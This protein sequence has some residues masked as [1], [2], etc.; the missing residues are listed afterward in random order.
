MKIDQAEL[1]ANL[2]VFDVKA[3]SFNSNY[4][5]VVLEREVV[6]IQDVESLDVCATLC[7]T[8]SKFLTKINGFELDSQAMQ[9]FC[10]FLDAT[11][12]KVID[13]D[14]ELRAYYGSYQL[15]SIGFVILSKTLDCGYRQTFCS[16]F[17]T[18]K[19]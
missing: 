17:K 3:F 15:Y 14:E 7:M 6:S 8:R 9:C 13:Q 16:I 4:T 19:L 10:S 11:L 1:K 18:F 2:T 5:D 12:C